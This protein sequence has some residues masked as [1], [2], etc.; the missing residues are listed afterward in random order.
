VIEERC[1]MA[2]ANLYGMADRRRDKRFNV[3]ATVNGAL[4][5][6]PDAVVREDTEGQWVGISRQ[7]AAV[8]DTF[9]LDIVQVDSLEGAVPRRV[10]VRVIE[11]RPVLIDGEVH[12]HIRLHGSV[13]AYVPFEQQVRRG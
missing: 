5:V 7:P 11:S 10:P 2:L 1:S 3:M 9:L 8:G 4:S 6:F 13:P 12:H